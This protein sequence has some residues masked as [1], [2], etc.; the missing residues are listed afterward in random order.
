LQYN[1]ANF[2]TEALDIEPLKFY[3]FKY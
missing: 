3:S 1:I 2:L